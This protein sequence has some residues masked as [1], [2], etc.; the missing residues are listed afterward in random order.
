[1]PALHT[2]I[3]KG[4]SSTYNSQTASGI[5]ALAVGFAETPVYASAPKSH[6]HISN[7]TDS[8]GLCLKVAAGA[9]T[10]DKP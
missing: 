3:F 1:M 7:I 9:M 6:N 4:Q 10:I 2:C 8:S 5:S